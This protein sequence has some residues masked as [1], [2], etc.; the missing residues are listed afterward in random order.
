MLGPWGNV[1]K[2][3]VTEREGED[4]WGFIKLDNSNWELKWWKNGTKISEHPVG[5]HIEIDGGDFDCDPRT[6]VFYLAW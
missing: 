5:K 2:M 3:T 1:N 4:N 6:G